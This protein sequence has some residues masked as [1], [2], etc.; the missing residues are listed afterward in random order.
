MRR[1]VESVRKY[2]SFLIIGNM[3]DALEGELQ[4]RTFK[5]SDRYFEKFE[6]KT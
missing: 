4:M 1:I 3:L 6:F 5:S 2:Y